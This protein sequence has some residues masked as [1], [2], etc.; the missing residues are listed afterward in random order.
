ME[1][2]PLLPIAR[3]LQEAVNARLL[4]ESGLVIDVDAAWDDAL[5]EVAR[6]LIAGRLET[7]DPELV[8]RL[9]ADQVDDAELHATLGEWAAR[10]ARELEHE[11]RRELLRREAASRGTIEL[12]RLDPGTRLR[13]GMFDAARISQARKDGSLPPGRIVELR[14]VDPARGSAEVISDTTL[15]F[16][17]AA[18]F[19]A[20]RRGDF[21]A[22]IT[23]D[24][25]CRLEPRLQLHAPLGY[26]LGDGPENSEEIIGYVEIDEGVL[27]L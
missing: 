14:L 10:K 1:A 27:V 11:E 3:A 7:L 9:Y 22:A 18:T 16:S 13:L 21:G 26:D 5:R 24:G 23:E 12:E 19:P 20:H 6:D 8:L 4:G 2:E 15:P 25:A 17:S